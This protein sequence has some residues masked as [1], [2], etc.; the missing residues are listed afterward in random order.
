MNNGKIEVIR[1]WMR[2]PQAQCIAL[3]AGVLLFAL[4]TPVQAALCVALFAAT[5]CADLVSAL[6]M[7]VFM[8]FMDDMT[9]TAFLGGSASR[10]M[11]AALLLRVLIVYLQTLRTEGKDALRRLKR[12]D[13]GLAAFALF[14]IVMGLIDHGLS[15]DAASFAVNAG[16][17]ILLRP[18]VRAR[19]AQSTL[20][21]LL[22]YY[23]RGALAAVLIGL[24]Q[25]RFVAMLLNDFTQS[26]ARFQGGS[27]PNFMAAH[28]S[29]AV[30]VHLSLKREGARVRDALITG[31]LGGAILL[32]YSMTGILCFVF[33]SIA[34]L[35][36]NRG[37]MKKLLLRIAPALPVAALCFALVTGYVSL[38]GV[39]AFNRGM[40][41]DNIHEQILYVTPEDYERMQQGAT[42][43]EVA[44]RA[45][46]ITAQEEQQRVV[47][48]QEAALAN[49][50]QGNALIIR[51]QEAIRRLKAG[52]YDALTSGRYG[53]LRMKLSDYAL[54]PLWQKALG[55]GPDATLTFQPS[56]N[57]LNYCH[58]S[59]ADMLYSV[60]FVGFA[61]ILLYI[62][63]LQRRRM[64]AGERMTGD[65]AR[66][67]FMGRTS[68]L[69]SAMVLSMH[70][71]RT[72][73]FFLIL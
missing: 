18:M 50:A 41:V 32:T 40:L 68:L 71:S 62:F 25:G 12:S 35:I 15:V 10:V 30:H 54:L 19:G 47:E 21:T 34:L 39:D 66:A 48:E 8:F 53:L 64:F 55:T 58:N 38:R 67:L 52:D 70:T 23:V 36:V 72:M 22:R 11:Q 73:L 51:L 4:G 60:G 57:Q 14:A 65:V 6:G 2:R 37:E 45:S 43:E 28:L 46:E 61:V 13:I 49:E 5:L 9:V 3:T 1:G 16:I 42:F 63:H 26:Y 44:V 33:A 56:A 69:L 7:Y 17:F 29:I 59:Y 24:V 20:E 27:E 31:I